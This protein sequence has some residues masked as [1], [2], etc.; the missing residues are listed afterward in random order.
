MN[1]NLIINIL[2][3][4]RIG[5]KW[6]RISRFWWQKEGRFGGGSAGA[7]RHQV[8]KTKGTWT[9]QTWRGQEENDGSIAA[10]ERFEGDK[11]DQSFVEEN[12]RTKYS[13]VDLSNDSGRSDVFLTCGCRFS[14]FASKTRLTPN[15]CEVFNQW[16]SKC[17]KIQLFKNGTA[18][19]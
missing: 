11:V 17:E 7:A 2:F 8:S 16:L 3:N 5:W 18:S 10:Q 6:S 19:L 9:R 1:W 4:S 12:T 15:P 13:K 14:A